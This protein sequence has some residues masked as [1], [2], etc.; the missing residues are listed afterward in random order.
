MKPLTKIEALEGVRGLALLPVFAVHYVTLFG[1]LLG[2]PAESQ[3]GW[4]WA[5]WGVDLFFLLSGYLVYG[6]LLHRQVS[7]AAFLRRRWRRIY[8]VYLVVF[9]LY[10]VLSAIFPERS[11]IP[12]GWLAGGWYVGANLLLLPGLFDIPPL[13]RVA[14]SLSYEMVFYTLLPAAVSVT[15]F[16]RRPVLARVAWLAGAGAAYWCASWWWGGWYSKALLLAP[17]GH[18]RLVLFLVGMVVREAHGTGWRLPGRAS[19]WGAWFGVVLCGLWWLPWTPGVKRQCVETVLLAVGGGPL[20]YWAGLPGN[21][22]ARALS[23]TGLRRLGQV[24][25][26]FYLV[27]G[28]VMHAI[29]FGVGLVWNGRAG[30]WWYGGLLPVV[31]CS[32]VGVAA[33]LYAQVERRLSFR[34]HAEPEKNRVHTGA[35]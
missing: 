3:A 31:F 12:S 34:S 10:L 13:I 32:A 15:G 30:S 17:L 14:W 7:A 29:V 16:L 8:P 9:A 22:L 18:P 11:K 26:S 5:Q 21:G 6:L 24:S 19:W 23:G 33:V 1:F 27:H 25:Y 28:L 35:L 4:E 2:R 20:I